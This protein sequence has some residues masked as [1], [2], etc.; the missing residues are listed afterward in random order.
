MVESISIKPDMLKKYWFKGTLSYVIALAIIAMLALFSHYLVQSIVKEQEATARVVNMA[1]RQ[2]MLTQRITLFAK[3]LQE[4]M[5]P[6]ERARLVNEYEDLVNTLE[7]MHLALM[8]GSVEENIP[9]PRTERIKQIFSQAPVNLDDKV[10][11]FISNAR[12]IQQRLEAGNNYQQTFIKLESAAH[13][14]ILEALDTLVFGFQSDSEIAI[15]QLRRYNKWSLI[16]MLATLLMEAVFIFRP[17]LMSLYRRENQYLSLLKAME[18]EIS[19]RVREKTFNDPLTG[20]PNREAMLEKIKTCIHLVKQEKAHLAVISIGLDRFKDINDSL[21]HDHGDELLQ[22]IANRLSHFVGQHNGII[23]R[24]TGD[25]FLLLLDRPKEHLEIINLMQQLTN[26][27]EMPYR[28]RKYNVQITASIGLAFYREDGSNARRLL[29]HANQAMRIAKDEGGHCFRFFQPAMT[30]K[31]MRRVRLEQQLREALQTHDQLELY[32]QPKIVLDTGQIT[33]VEALIRWNH[34]DEGLL[35]PDEFI[36][37]A[38]DSG[39]IIPLGEWVLEESFRQSEQWKNEGHSIHVAINISIKQL[40]D[41]NIIHHVAFL[42]QKYNVD[43][44]MIELEITENIMMEN[45]KFILSQLKILAQCGFKLAIDDFGTGHSSLATL[46]DLPVDVLKIDRS[47]VS[48][49]MQDKRDQQI[50]A[51]IIEMGHSLNKEIVAE[52]IETI[53]QMHFLKDLGCDLGQGYLFAK[54]IPVEEFNRLLSNIDLQ[55]ENMARI[56]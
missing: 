21:G 1:G 6:G 10:Q 9:A 43:S 3:E 48:N 34:P 53:A 14:S 11:A 22:Q 55:P 8:N 52:G 44:P 16:G 17:L 46:R 51:A 45:L 30:S 18:D 24:I 40:M 4:P 15:A 41:E 54:P 42:G 2:R 36:P 35:S 31:M 7:R 29:L 13:K 33:G 39:L 12:T 27:I 25:E 37:I 23:G 5:S 28:W 47:F 32:Y 20:L 49:A 56:Q 26:R 19:E 38:E 50:V